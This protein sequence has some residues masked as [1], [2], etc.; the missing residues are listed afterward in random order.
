GSPRDEKPDFFHRGNQLL[1]CGKQAFAVVA[2]WWTCEY[3]IHDLLDRGHEWEL[4]ARR[5]LQQKSRNDEA[6]DFVR[7]LEDP[8]DSCVAVGTFGGILF[9]EAVAAVDLHSFV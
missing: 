7:A 6:I 8:V 4:A 1:L 5:A 3:F 2:R 9:D